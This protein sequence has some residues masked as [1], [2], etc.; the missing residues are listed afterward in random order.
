MWSCYWDD[1]VPVRLKENISVKPPIRNASTALIKDISTECIS[2]ILDTNP[3]ENINIMT[4]DVNTIDAKYNNKDL[5]ISIQEEP[6]IISQIN[7]KR[8][9]N[10]HNKTC[11]K[12]TDNLKSIDSNVQLDNDKMKIEN[13]K[14]KCENVLNKHIKEQNVR[15]AQNTNTINNVRKIKKIEK[16]TIDTFSGKTNNKISVHQDKHKNISN[17]NTNINIEH[18]LSSPLTDTVQ[19][20]TH[21]SQHKEL[22]KLESPK[23]ELLNEATKTKSNLNVTMMKIDG[24]PPI[25]LSFEIPVSTPV[26][27]TVT[28]NIEQ[29]DCK[30]NVTGHMTH[31]N[32]LGT[33]NISTKK[34]ITSGRLYEKFSFT[35]I[36]KKMETNNSIDVKSKSNNVPNI[37]S[38]IKTEEIQNNLINNVKQEKDCIENFHDNQSTINYN[39][40]CKQITSVTN[41]TNDYTLNEVNKYE[42]NLPNQEDVSNS[43]ETIS[44]TTLNSTANIENVLTDFLINDYSVSEDINDEWINSL[45]S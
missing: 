10:V 40:N 20:I 4:H 42:P 28:C 39:K 44:D 1:N 13:I 25:T 38:T 23:N 35:A 21:S 33:K 30:T 34:K 37:K 9:H 22:S 27:E 32:T 24:L 8:T 5:N 31:T 12:S 19:S 43:Q 14:N 41:V 36:K 16:S 7:T 45:L 18:N 11:S 26:S 2:F 15:Y 3:S 6:N 17:I 29:N